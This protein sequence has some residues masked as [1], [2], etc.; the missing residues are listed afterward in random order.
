M[1]SFRR[2]MLALTVLALFAGLAS[3]QVQ[4][5]QLTCATNVS[6]TPSLRSEGFTE[7]AGDITLNCTGGVAIA[8]GSQIPAVNIQIFTNTAIT[9][10]LIGSGGASEALLLI[11]EPGSGLPGYGPS[12]P[13]NVCGTPSVGCIQYVGTQA[14][15]TLGTA[16]AGPSPSVTPGAN[17]FQG[18]VAGNSVTFFGVPVLPPVT[19]GASRVFRITNIRVNANTLGGGGAAPVVAQISISGATSLLITNPTPTIGFVQNGLVSGTTKGSST[20]SLQQCVSAAQVLVNT[21]TFT[22][23]FGTAFKTR[24]AA[25]STAQYAGQTNA[26]TPP[27]N[28]PGTI[29][30]S[31][32]NFVLAIPGQST[33]AGL[34]DYGTRLKASFSGIPAN[35]R[36]FV[37][38]LVLGANATESTLGG[39]AANIGT[40]TAAVLVSSETVNDGNAT[41]GFFPSAGTTALVEIPVS[42]TGTATAVW[43]VMNTN[44]NA[45]DSFS[46]GVYAT[47]TAN[48]ATNS[49]TPGAGSVTLGFAPTPPAFSATDGV[50][51]SAS[52]T[53][54]RFAPTG[55]PTAPI[56]NINIC[57]T[58]LLYPY[59]TN[60][61]G[62]DSGIAVANTT[63]DPSIG[64]DGKATTGAQAGK[65]TFNWY[66]GPTN[67]PNYETPTIDAGTTWASLTSILV[68]GFG[69]GGPSG[70]GYAIAVCNFQFAHGFA[71]IQDVGGRNFGMAYLALII[72]DVGVGQRAANGLDKAPAGTGEN[73]AH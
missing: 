17:V 54:P 60:T 45:I 64:T 48:V 25:Q 68:P 21:L 27:Q 35:T 15:P 34:A 62:Y 36:L 39:S 40:A 55:L 26:N 49:P 44:P 31:E 67:P 71:V 37:T 3:A 10:R 63:K 72:P 8:P 57:R 22:E 38:R 42:P 1:V 14:G 61:S 13:Q 58:V 29:Y 30:N 59:L 66:Q 73:T 6:V 11:D 28:I 24:V 4:T 9:S 47:Y 32:S 5:Q 33:V 56:F 70:S 19:A 43:E 41:G 51:A 23:N 2:C 46:V 52:L 50:K 65:C 12:L 53:I 7:Q 16:V 69:S 20:T 18:V